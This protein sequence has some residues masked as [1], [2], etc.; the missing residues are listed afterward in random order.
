MIKKNR[1]SLGQVFLKDK[2]VLFDILNLV[3]LSSD[4]LVLE[5]GSGEGDLTSLLLKN[6]YQVV[7]VEI[8]R[9]LF[10]KTK[11]LFKENKNLLLYNQDF[12]KFDLSEIFKLEPDKNK[13]KV[14]ANIPY[15]LTSPILKI[16]L[17]ENEIKKSGISEHTPLF[18]EIYIMVQKEVANRLTGSPGHKAYGAISIFVQYCS[19]VEILL[20]VSKNSFNPIPKVDSTFI[21]LTPFSKNPI[22]INNPE[23]FWN[24]VRDIFSTRR[25]TL[26]N[27]LRTSKFFSKYI[28]HLSEEID[29][30]I[31]GETL[32]INEL[33][34]ISNII[35][36]IEGD[37]FKN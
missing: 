13:R 8:D 30:K 23:I 12:L 15:N 35:D 14:I 31:R 20:E 10:N 5:I 21:K 25:K 11:D 32:N 4:D 37:I 9:H 17:N 34:R 27:S 26:K 18:S 33:A 28:N 19:K 22:K 2:N 29:L 3:N 7:S 16:L 6:A 1:K 24:L 36:K